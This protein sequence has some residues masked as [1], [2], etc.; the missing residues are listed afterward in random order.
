MSVEFT[1]ECVM[2]TKKVFIIIIIIIIIIVLLFSAHWQSGF[3]NGPGD[4]GSIPHC[5]Y[6]R[7]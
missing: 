5:T 1:E 7:F 3:A 2:C 6:Q 4:L